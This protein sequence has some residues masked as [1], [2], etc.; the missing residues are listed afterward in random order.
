MSEYSFDGTDIKFRFS[1][2]DANGLIPQTGQSAG[3]TI[4]AYDSAKNADAVTEVVSEVGGGAYEALIPYSEIYRTAGDGI[5]TFTFSHTN[6][7]LTFWPPAVHILINVAVGTVTNADFA[8]TTTQAEF[9]GLSDTTT[10]H[11][12][13][14]FIH[15]LTGNNAGEVSKVSASSVVVTNPRL[16][17]GT[18]SAALANGDKIVVINR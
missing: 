9:T 13:S 5:W 6:P 11:Y 15:V 18:L 2:L 17:F 1:I 16:T 7:D 4:T 12:K 10:D 8:P 14:S 3:V